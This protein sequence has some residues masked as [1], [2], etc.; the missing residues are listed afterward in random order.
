MNNTAIFAHHTI[1][2]ARQFHSTTT[3]CHS[4]NKY[5]S[6]SIFK[7]YALIYRIASGEMLGKDQPVILQLLE[8]P[9]AL[10]KLKG[11]VM[12]L[13]DCAFPLLRGVVQTSDEQ[14]AFEGAY[15]LI[16]FTTHTSQTHYS[17]L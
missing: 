16:Y 17:L 4:Y 8:L 12:E 6:Y 3:S 15:P 10:T 5:F 1:L 14:K 13:E 7:G 2:H 9:D 11:T